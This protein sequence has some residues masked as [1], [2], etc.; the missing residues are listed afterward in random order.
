MLYNVD[1]LSEEVDK[2]YPNFESA[3]EN[4]MFGVFVERK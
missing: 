2:R 4:N 1:K 3:R